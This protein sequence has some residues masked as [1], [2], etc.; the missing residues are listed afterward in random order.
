MSMVQVFYTLEQLCQF[1][2]DQFAYMLKQCIW[3]TSC[4]GRTS[5]RCVN[6]VSIRVPEAYV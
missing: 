2:G 3:F 6:L 1:D 4:L 5:A